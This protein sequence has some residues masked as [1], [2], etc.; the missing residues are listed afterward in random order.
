MTEDFPTSAGKSEAG[1]DGEAGTDRLSRQ[2]SFRHF[3]QLD[4]FRG[5]SVVIVVFGHFLEFAGYGPLRSKIGHVMAETGVFLFFVLSGF[6]ITGIL[7]REKQEKGHIDFKRFYIRR[8]LRLGP[9]LL[10]FL[11]IIIVFNNLGL[12]ERIRSYEFAACLFYVR[13]F[14]GKSQTLGHIWSLSLEEQFYLCWPVLLGTICRKHILPVTAT[15]TALVAIWRGVAIHLDLF[16]YGRGIYYVRPYFRFDSILIGA[17]LV[18]GLTTSERFRTTARHFAKVV[19]AIVLWLCLALWS[20]WG[21]ALSRS[22]YLTLQMLLIVAIL[23]QLALG[24]TGISMEFFRNKLL[25]Y[26]G[27]I[28][29][30]LYLWQQIFLVVKTPSWGLLRYFP[31]SVGMSVLIAM[32]SFHV[33]ETP[34][35]RLKQHFE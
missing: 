3:P 7:Q 18:V 27:R 29:Y 23:G 20:F 17:W 21:E 25:R 1:A 10:A 6:L 34:A 28:S 4:G 9:A 13:N 35:L 24:Q 26:L 8:A 2:Y 32:L 16:D 31:I 11:L 22:Y 33:L 5:L 15:L 14:F 30:S 12:V 19:P